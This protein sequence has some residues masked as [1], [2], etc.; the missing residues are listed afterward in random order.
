MSCGAGNRANG[1][2]SRHINPKLVEL[3]KRA[4]RLEE[5]LTALLKEKESKK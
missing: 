4:A 2:I 3:D 1:E 5:K